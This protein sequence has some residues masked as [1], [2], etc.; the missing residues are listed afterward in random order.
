MEK[1]YLVGDVG[2]TNTRLKI[3]SDNKRI[4]LVYDTRQLDGLEFAINESLAKAKREGI[5]VEE[6]CLGVA[7]PVEGRVYSKPPFIDWEIDEDRIIRE[8]GLEEVIIINDFEALGWGINVLRGQDSKRLSDVKEVIRGAKC[9]I[10]AGSGLGASI[11]I[12]DET[13]KIYFPL[14][15]EGGHM[16]FHSKGEEVD[17]IRYIKLKEDREIICYADL[18]SG[19]GLEN[20]YRSFG[21]DNGLTA[22]NIAGNVNFIA[23]KARNTFSRIYGRFAGSMALVSVP[24]GGLYIAGG[25]AIKNPNLVDNEIFRKEFMNVCSHMDRTIGRIPL[26]LITNENIGLEGAEFYLKLQNE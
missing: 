19:K 17:I 18:L 4:D 8:T 13:M 5:H 24:V 2:G 16:R 21:G 1:G 3:V 7:G 14:A 23:E 6:A 10:G 9:L 25:I 12:Y 26:S 22:D 20:I 15:S 11:L